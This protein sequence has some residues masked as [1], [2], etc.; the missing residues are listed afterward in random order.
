M[1]RNPIHLNGAV[2][3]DDRDEVILFDKTYRLRPITRSVERTLLAVNTQLQDIAKRADE[4]DADQDALLDELVA[5]R[6][7]GIDA[8]LA[9]DGT[10]RTSA[11]KLLQEKWERDEVTSDQIQRYLTLLTEDEEEARPTST[12]TS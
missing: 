3:D 6:I 12:T 10:H 7:A 2:S 11:A 8:L 9:I 5:N 4:D 1:P